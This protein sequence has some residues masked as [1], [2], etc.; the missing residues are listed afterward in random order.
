L[1]YQPIQPAVNSRNEEIANT[2]TH[3]IGAILAIAA[4]AGLIIAAAISGEPW[5][6]VTLSIFSATLIAVY[7]TSTLYHAANRPGLKHVLRRLD[8][9][10]IFLLIAGSYTPFML[11]TLGGGWGWS[12][13]SV[14]WAL[15]GIGIFLKLAKFG[16]HHRIEMGIKL[17]SGWLIVIAI[18]PVFAV[19]SGP[20]LFW[21]IAGGLAY[22]VGI[23]FF[24]SE[25]LNFNHAIWHVF[26]LLGSACH[27]AAMVTDVLPM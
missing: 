23:V 26:V 8:H 21:L 20:G 19:M 7:L 12:L 11:V 9:A 17:I 6:I 10:A 1:A 16:R 18:V 15:A 25:R 24:L 22:T 4:A 2:V 14:V 3:G 27:I 13:F 5:R